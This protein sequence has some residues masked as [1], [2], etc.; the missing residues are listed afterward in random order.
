[1]PRESYSDVVLRLATGDQPRD[2]SM[3]LSDV[4]EPTRVIVCEPC[5][6]RGSK[7]TVRGP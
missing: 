3:I 2:G 4:R 5:G 6:R 1:M 7:S